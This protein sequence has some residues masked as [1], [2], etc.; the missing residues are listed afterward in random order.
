MLAIVFSLEQSVGI[1]LGFT[2]KERSA[3]VGSRRLEH[4]TKIL[5]RRQLI[6]SVHRRENL[7]LEYGDEATADPPTGRDAAFYLQS[8]SVI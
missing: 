6:V 3:P 7:A 4:A 8:P 2:V 1:E 5:Q